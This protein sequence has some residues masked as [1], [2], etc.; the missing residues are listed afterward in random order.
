MSFFYGFTDELMKI[1]DDPMG[2]YTGPMAAGGVGGSIIGGLTAEKGKRLKDALIL[3]LLGAGVGAG[4]EYWSRRKSEKTASAPITVNNKEDLRDAL[5]A[6]AGIG[7]LS[8]AG[9]GFL[10]NPGGL[11]SRLKAGGKLGLAGAVAS[12]L[13]AAIMNRGTVKD[14]LKEKG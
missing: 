8:G 3:G 14:I 11:K 10:M 5:G 12:P 9:W 2:E 1:A 7:G 4:R 13:A 6:I